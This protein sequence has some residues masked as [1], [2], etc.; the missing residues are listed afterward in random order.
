MNRPLLFLD[1][2]GVLNPFA[3]PQMPDG[4]S[5]YRF[6]VH[7]EVWLMAGSIPPARP[8]GAWLNP[9]FHGPMLRDLALDFDLVWATSWGN[10]ANIHLSPL[11]GLPMLPIVLPV[12][13]RIRVT[14]KVGPINRFA[15]DRPLAWVDDDP[16]PSGAPDAFQWARSRRGG[17]HGIPTLVLPIDPARGLTEGNADELRTFA[18]SLR[19]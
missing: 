3:A 9:R 8:A 15:G 5:E 11:F 10:D 17:A 16:R 4:F 14:T 19:A 12:P 18:R 1:V 7:D 6:M 13:C 2:D